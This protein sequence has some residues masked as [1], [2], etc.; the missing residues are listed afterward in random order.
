MGGLSVW[1]TISRL[2]CKH[3]RLCRTRP[4]TCLLAAAAESA[5]LA[6]V[7]GALKDF[8]NSFRKGNSRSVLWNFQAENVA[9]DGHRAPVKSSLRSITI[10]ACSIRGPAAA[11]D[12]ML[13][14]YDRSPCIDVATA[15]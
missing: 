14:G 8:F 13:F 9:A 15:A 12:K 11:G 6:P 5:C 10:N 2:T 7:G 1:T 4:V 3:M